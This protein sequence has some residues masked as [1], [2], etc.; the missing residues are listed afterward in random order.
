MF[1]AD[2]FCPAIHFVADMFCRR[3]VLSPICFVTD[4]FCHQY[5]L[6]RHVLSRY[7][8]SRYVLS[9]YLSLASGLAVYE[10]FC[11]NC[12]LKQKHVKKCRKNSAIFACFTLS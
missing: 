3:Y 8:L 10:R 4:M 1:V 6:G 12:A 11:F 2:T 5:V 9:M 7:V